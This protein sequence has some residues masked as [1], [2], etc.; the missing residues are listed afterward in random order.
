VAAKPIKMTPPPTSSKGTE[1]TSG[2]G[3]G[4]VIGALL[5]GL[6]GAIVL[7]VLQLQREDAVDHLLKDTDTPSSVIE[8]P[9]PT[10]IPDEPATQPTPSITQPTTPLPSS[11]P[12]ETGPLSVLRSIPADGDAD[13]DP[14][15]FILIGFSDEVDGST[16]TPASVTLSDAHDGKDF[17]D[18]FTFSYD[19]RELRLTI[20]DDEVA[21]PSERTIRVSLGATIMSVSGQPLTSGYQFSFT[22]R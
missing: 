15:S 3:L 10:V 7:L 16:L 21:L 6:L 18:R 14:K 19:D 2:L 11:T 4:V 20:T 22:T 13:I 8:I 9:R 17:T 1:K 5:G 12:A